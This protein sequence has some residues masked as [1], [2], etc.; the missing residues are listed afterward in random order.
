[1][2]INEKTTSTAEP[3]QADDGSL[4]R[5]SLLKRGGL[6][7][8]GALL[9]GTVGAAC[10][11]N[12]DE[13][14]DAEAAEAAA[15]TG[16]ESEPKK[17]VWA[18]HFFFGQPIAL[19]IPVGFRDF[20]EPLGWEFEMF[21]PQDHGDVQQ[22][23]SA[24]QQ[25][26]QSGADAIVATMNDPQAFNETLGRIADSETKFLLNNTQPDEG[27]PWRAP[28]VGQSFFES[29]VNSTTFL[30]DHIVDVRGR[31]DGVILLG[32]C[33]PE[34]AAVNTRLAGMKEGIERY[35][36][37]QGTSFAFD[38]FF[39]ESE[40]DLTQSV[41]IWTA[42][43]R[44]HGDNAVGSNQTLI[45]MAAVEAAGE[46][47]YEAGEI[48][49]IIFDTTEERSDAIKAGWLLGVVDQ[50]PYVQ[51]YMS[52]VHAWMML[53]RA[54]EPPVVYDSGS[55]IITTENVEAA[56]ERDQTIARLAENYGYRI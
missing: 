45:G 56:L 42:K 43:M 22:T 16:S 36:N 34:A 13:S 8:G 31:R 3:G 18:S 21:A 33:C 20:L 5:R 39:D 2:E 4:D 46:L 53:E 23:I 7:A 1:M 50:Q 52:A 35:N 54:S 17:V 32:R 48:P 51:G 47:G 29:G 30:L 28:F 40:S 19:G 49:M 10:T 38:E 41:S 15:R 9:F 24:Q 37:E 44:E 14:E 26:L 11:G 55:A 12:G 25:A 27:N 6:V